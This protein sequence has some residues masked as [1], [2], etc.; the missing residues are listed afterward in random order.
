M[1]STHN[2]SLAEGHVDLDPPLVET[3][4]PMEESMGDHSSIG[5]SLASGVVGNEGELT[6]RDLLDLTDDGFCRVIMTVKGQERVCSKPY[7]G[8][9]RARHNALCQQVGRRAPPAF[10]KAY[11]NSRGIIDG[12]LEASYSLEEAQAI[13]D[14][15]LDRQATELGNLATGTEEDGTPIGGVEETKEDPSVEVVFGPQQEPALGPRQE[16]TR[17]ATVPRESGSDNQDPSRPSRRW[18]GLEEPYTGDREVEEDVDT[19]KILKELGWN[20]KQVFS[21]LA[22][23]MVWKRG[24][25]QKTVQAPEDPKGPTP[26]L[27]NSVPETPPR[28][29]RN[30][31]H[32]GILR[33]SFNSTRGP[34]TP[35]RG[36]E[37]VVFYGMEHSGTTDRCVARARADADL[38]RDAGYAIRKLFYSLAEA[39]TWEGGQ[40]V[41]RTRARGLG[42]S[43]EN[44]HQTKVGPD[45]STTSKEVF[46]VHMDFYEEMDA[47]CLPHGTLPGNTDDLYDCATDVMALPGGYRSSG[48][49]DDDDEGDVAKALMT[50]A[51]GKKETGI[52]MRFNSK[53]QNGLRQIKGPDD[54]SEFV[55]SVH[56][57]WQH[58]EETMHSQFTR[59]MY[60]GGHEHSS[61][62]SYLQNG[63]LPRLVTD[64][65]K[66]YSYFLTT[67]VG[68]VNKMGPSEAWKTSVASALL[69]QH[70]KA[71]GLIR[72]SSAS[73]R[74]LLLRNYAYMRDQ[75]K[76][77]FWNDKLSKKV[78]VMTTQAMAKLVRGTHSI[79]EGSS[80]GANCSVCNRKHS[81][82]PCP[83]ESFT[84]A[85]RTKLGSGLGQRKYEKALR[86]IKDA[87]AQDP[88]ASHDTLIEA[89]RK[90]AS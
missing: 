44:T 51:T 76:T 68:Y 86:H 46:G 45:P 72:E 75:S 21:D 5:E 33:P 65:Y 88:K 6:F 61:I 62:T 34:G 30:N 89:A 90:S 15:E 22:E 2:E 23:A 41:Q 38:L 49:E 73:Y 18:I 12:V 42:V 78:A 50:I 87:L 70:E 9:S 60:K 83:V 48:G 39:T 31:G 47:M 84:T 17:G 20:A 52:H 7:L 3:A 67:L 77:S 55:E 82:R 74:E 43:Q 40:N 63:V 35:N 11:R 54:L 19:A 80:G 8:C 85:E 36:P 4:D 16:D 66:A 57:A 71:L 79:S 25:K 10:Y 32:A 27:E 29:V 59:K 37:Q 1:S 26:P 14:A 13:R 56:E 28:T 64:T 24:A 81:G 58:A 69:R 53:S